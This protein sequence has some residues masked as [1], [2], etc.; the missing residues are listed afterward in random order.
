MA[1]TYTDTLV[2]D[3]DKV[4][5]AIGDTVEA[6][7]P[8]PEDGNFTDA[9]VDGLL[10]LEGSWGRAAA[11]A[12]E[13][14]SALWA[15]HVSFGADGMS[16]SQSDIANQYRQSA[17]EWRKKYGTSIPAGAGAFGSTAPIRADGYS[18]DLDSIETGIYIDGVD[19]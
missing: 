16:A 15:K 1:F 10:A 9:E 3:R 19:L 17:T 14:L 11:A 13:A 12:F 5:F 18:D 8:K 7:G 4:R 2:S 6:S